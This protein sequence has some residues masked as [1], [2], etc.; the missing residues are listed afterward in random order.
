MVFS[1]LYAGKKK[2]IDT[3]SRGSTRHPLFTYQ[4]AYWLLM[5]LVVVSILA[6]PTP[7][8]FH[9]DEGGYLLALSHLVSKRFDVLFE[10]LTTPTLPVLVLAVPFYWAGEG[11]LGSIRA[12]TVV[13]SLVGLIAFFLLVYKEAACEPSLE[14]AAIASAFVGLN[15]LFYRYTH[16]F[17]GD[18]GFLAFCLLSLLFYRRYLETHTK[19][20][21]CAAVVFSTMAIYTRQFGMILPCVVG[22][23]LLYSSIR[24]RRALDVGDLVLVLVP[25]LAFVPLAM[26]FYMQYGSFLVPTTSVAPAHHQFG[27]QIHNV[28]WCVNFI[29]IFAI[30]FAPWIVSRYSLVWKRKPVAIGLLALTPLIL[31]SPVNVASFQGGLG[32][33]LTMVPLLRSL[34]PVILLASQ[35]MGLVVLVAL[36]EDGRR[37][38]KAAYLLFLFSVGYMCALALKGGYLL[39]HYATPFVPSV[40]YVVGNSWG[41]MRGRVSKTCFVILLVLLWFFSFSWAA[42]E[43][44]TANASYEAVRL[45]QQKAS[46]NAL[47]FCLSST[48]L[49]H[50]NEGLMTARPEDSDFII[51]SPEAPVRFTVPEGFDEIATFP[52]SVY[53]VPIGSVKVY[54]KS[55]E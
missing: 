3:F 31:W 47:V 52:V 25:W 29:G 17:T 26:Y 55:G 21:L 40:A 2:E 45:V 34:L 30:P 20:T 38:S 35:W 7:Q 46:D 51:V 36:F 28:L 39:V 4:L 9:K 14:Q 15:P 6:V 43:R 54:E 18:T 24:Y 1:S 22:L 19:T 37:G 12:L 41:A 32:K 33:I 11:S 50:F 42:S 16:V 8:S 5:L 53:G 10:K 27:L 23:Y 13:L 49:W 48:A 44:A